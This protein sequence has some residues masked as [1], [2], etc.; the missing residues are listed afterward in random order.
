MPADPRVEHPGELPRWIVPH[1][2]PDVVAALLSAAACN[3][4]CS[5]TAPQNDQENGTTMPIFI[6]ANLP[7][8]T[9]T[10]ARSG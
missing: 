4:A 5:T 8:S 1:D 10:I 3:S 2:Q 6:G 7:A 9:R